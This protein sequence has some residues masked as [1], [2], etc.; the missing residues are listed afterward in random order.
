MAEE[1]STTV[2]PSQTTADEE[3]PSTTMTANETSAD[4]TP[5]GQESSAK[6]DAVASTATPS[7]PKAALAA[8]MA[9]FKALQAQKVSGRKATEREVRDAEDRSARLAQISK[10]SAAHDKA[11]YKLLKSEDPDFERKR[12]WDYTIEE[13]ESWDKRLKKKAK[14]REGVAFA[15]YRNEA[16]KVYKRQIGQMNKVDMEAYAEE[17]ARKL[18]SQVSSGLLQLV[19][20]DAGEIYTVDSQGRINT[21]VDEAYSHDHKP[22]KEAVD[23][24]VE[25]LEKSERARLKAR[26]ARGIRDEQDMGDVTYINQKNKQFNDKLAR[27][28]NRY[29]TEIR[30]SFER[31]T[32][33]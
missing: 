26:A 1:S 10:L 11:S 31:G 3:A 21:P 33:I 23:R 32:A 13:S 7:D 18:Q 2:A 4:N 30:E 5:T 6:E 19:E 22:S 8:R 20:T 28:Y 29:T 15:D 16:N 9:R 17:K 14:N 12:N 24:L 27:F 25:D